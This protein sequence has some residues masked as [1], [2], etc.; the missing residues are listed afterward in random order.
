MSLPL[1]LANL[2]GK[3]EMLVLDLGWEEQL[4]VY[5]FYG[6]T[7][8]AGKSGGNE[9]AKVITEILM[10]NIQP[11]VYVKNMARPPRIHAHHGGL[12]C[13]PEHLRKC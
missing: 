12:Q 13:H 3:I 7:G 11:F 6:K 8:G 4:T 10:E 1:K 9:G 2:P 5:T